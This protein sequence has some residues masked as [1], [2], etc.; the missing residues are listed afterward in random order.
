M[1]FSLK[2]DQHKPKNQK[3]LNID[4]NN[5]CLP[6][7]NAASMYVYIFFRFENIDKQNQTFEKKL[8]INSAPSSSTGEVT[9]G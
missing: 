4:F 7:N 8:N 2:I 6:C 3:R 5:L 1:F 9:L